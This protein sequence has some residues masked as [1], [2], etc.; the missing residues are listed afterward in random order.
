M[1]NGIQRSRDEVT[2]AVWQASSW[3]PFVRA[4]G[5][6][7][8]PWF[9]DLNVSASG[10]TDVVIKTDDDGEP[11]LDANG[12]TIPQSSI[13]GAAISRK[14]ALLL[15]L[16]IA[17]AVASFFG[18]KK[19]PMIMGVVYA[20]LFGVKGKLKGM[21]AKLDE[22]LDVLAAMDPSSTGSEETASSDQILDQ[23]RVIKDVLGNADGEIGGLIEG[24]LLNR[25]APV[26]NK[27]WFEGVDDPLKEDI[28][29]G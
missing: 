26:I 7:W 13:D 17:M 19:L 8:D 4:N 15:T 18:I 10:W 5:S 9:Q 24:L 2:A 1:I 22:I 27:D 16:V 12:N 21:E 3:T 29:I 11:I 14:T 25:R 6:V 23:I 28:K 20:K